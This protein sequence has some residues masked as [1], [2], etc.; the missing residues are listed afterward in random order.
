MNTISDITI[1]PSTSKNTE[2][3]RKY[4]TPIDKTIGNVEND[5]VVIARQ[6]KV[7]VKLEKTDQSDYIKKDA[8]LIKLAEQRREKKAHDRRGFASRYE[9]IKSYRN[10]AYYMECTIAQR[11]IGYNR[12]HKCKCHSL[13][14]NRISV[15]K[16]DG[17]LMY[18]FSCDRNFYNEKIRKPVLYK[19]KKV[20]C[21][22]C[23]TGTLLHVTRDCNCVAYICNHCKVQE[24]HPFGDPAL[25]QPY[26]ACGFTHKEEKQKVLDQIDSTVVEGFSYASAAKEGVDKEQI[27]DKPDAPKQLKREIVDMQSK[28]YKR[29]Q[30]FFVRQRAF[31]RLKGIIDDDELFENFNKRLEQLNLQDLR[32]L[33]KN[34]AVNLIVEHFKNHRK[35]EEKKEEKLQEN[36]T[37][38]EVAKKYGIKILEK[39][40]LHGGKIS[41]ATGNALA[42]TILTAGSNLVKT[43]VNTIVEQI[44]K[45]KEAVMKWIKDKLN[46]VT[47]Y[48]SEFTGT[49]YAFLE[50]F[51]KFL[52]FLLEVV[53]D[54]L[55]AS[56]GP[57]VAMLIYRCIIG[58]A[59]NFEIA[60]LIPIFADCQGIDPTIIVHLCWMMP[61][62]YTLYR[63]SL[64]PNAKQFGDYIMTSKTPELSAV[65]AAYD[66]LADE[67]IIEIHGG[68][69]GQ[70]FVDGF[71]RFS[72]IK[73]G[74]GDA[75]IKYIQTFNATIQACR[76]LST[77]VNAIGKLI[78]KFVKAWFRTT[79]PK[80]YVMEQLKVEGSPLQAMTLSALTIS[81]AK[82]TGQ[83]EDMNKLKDEYIK[84]KVAVYEDLSKKKMYG[85]EIARYI[86]TLDEQTV[87]PIK[88]NKE[89]REPF[90]VRL[91]G[92]P[93]T[94]KSTL[95]P[96]FISAM[97]NITLEEASRKTYF[98][99]SASEYMDGC[100]KG[101][102]YLIY[103]DFN[104]D[105]METDLKE[106]ILIASAG[107]L[108]P[109]FSNIDP[110]LQST[111]G[112]KGDAINIK[113]IVLCSN[114]LEINPTSLNSKEAI[115]RRK[116][117]TYRFTHRK[118]V[119][120]DP[121]TFKHLE[122]RQVSA[123]YTK[124]AA[125]D[126][127]QPDL[128]G[129]DLITAARQQVRDEYLKFQTLNAT[130]NTSLSTL[131]VTLHGEDDLFDVSMFEVSRKPKPL[132]L[133]RMYAHDMLTCLIHKSKVLLDTIS[134]PIIQYF[135][136]HI[137]SEAEAFA[138]A[139]S[140]ASVL[141]IV[142]I[143]IATIETLRFLH[144]GEDKN[145]VVK[146]KVQVHSESEPDHVSRNVA[147][148]QVGTRY[149]NCL[150]VSGNVCLIPRH[151][152]WD[153]K[154]YSGDKLLYVDQGTPCR[155]QQVGQA[156]IEF[157][158][159][160][161]SVAEINEKGDYVLYQMPPQVASK[162]TIVSSFWDGTE[163]LSGRKCI[164]YQMKGTTRQTHWGAVISDRLSISSE[165]GNSVYTHSCILT[166]LPSNLGDCGAPIMCNGMN[167][168]KIVGINSG[169]TQSR[170]NFVVLVTRQQIEKGLDKLKHFQRG[171]LHSGRAPTIEE[172]EMSPFANTQIELVAIS[173]HPIVP[174]FKT[175]IRPS[176]LFDKI[177]EHV[178]EPCIIN[179]RDPRLKGRNVYREN[180]LKY[181]KPAH[182]L[183]PSYRRAAKHVIET[184]QYHPSIR[185]KRKL[186]L[187]EAINGVPNHPY[188]TSMEMTTSAGLPWVQKGLVGPKR[189]LF[190]GE[191]PNLYPKPEL[192]K[193]IDAILLNIKEG[194]L[195]DIPYLATIK[196]ERKEIK[197]VAE[198]KSRMFTIPGV[199]YS[200]VLRMYF[201]PTLAHMYQCRSDTFMSIGMN[202]ASDE[203]DTMV[204]YLQEVGTSFEDMDY[205]K[206]DTSAEINCRLALFPLFSKYL[207]ED[208]QF[209]AETL[210]R[211]DAQA[212]IQWDKYILAIPGGTCSGSVLTAPIGSLIN[213]V[214][215]I[216]SWIEL[217]PTSFKDP[218]YFDK[219]V[220]NKNYGDDLAMVVADQAKYFFNATNISQFLAQYNIQMTPGDKG[221][222]FTEKTVYTFTYLKNNTRLFNGKYVPLQQH[223]EEPLNWIRQDSKSESPEKCCEDNCNSVLRALFFYGPER[224]N[225][226]RESILEWRNYK[227]ITFE[228]LLDE[229]TQTGTLADFE[230]T[231]TFS[232]SSP[233]FRN[234]EELSP[235]LHGGE[236]NKMNTQTQETQTQEQQEVVRDIPKLEA[237]LDPTRGCMGIA[238]NMP[239][240]AKTTHNDLA[241]SFGKKATKLIRRFYAEGK[242]EYDPAERYPCIH[243]IRLDQFFKNAPRP[244][245]FNCYCQLALDQ[246]IQRHR[247]ITQLRANASEI[248]SGT[249]DNPASIISKNV[250]VVLSEQ[251]QAEVVSRVENMTVSSN[252]R[253]EKFNPDEAYTLS[254]MLKRNNLIGTVPW[255]GAQTPNTAIFKADILQEVITNLIAATPFR[256]FHLARFK[257]IVFRFETIGYRFARGRLIA[258]VL[259]TQRSRNYIKNDIFNINTAVY[260]NGIS[261][262]P[263]NA[264]IGE[265]HVDY[266]FNKQYID[267]VNEDVLGQLFL[268]VQN[269]FVPGTGGAA[270]CE[271][272]IFM[273]IEEAEFK[274]PTAGT[275]TSFRSMAGQ[276]H[277]LD[278]LIDAGAEEV[279]KLAKEIIP[280]NLVGDLLAGVLDAP[281]IG[282]QP[283]VIVQKQIQYLNNSKNFQY[284]DVMTLDPSAQQL[285]DPEVFSTQRDEMKMSE[286]F[287]KAYFY[288][289]YPWTRV[290]SV[291]TLLLS[292]PVGPLFEAYQ[293]TTPIAA[294]H[295]SHMS[296]LGTLFQYWRGGIEY[297]FEIVSSQMH[298]GKID[299]CFHP[300]DSPASVDTFSY[301]ARLSQYMS[302]LH[303]RNGGN[304]FRIIVPYLGDAPVRSVYQGQ[305]VSDTFA[306]AEFRFQ[307]FFSGTVSLNVSALLSA[308]DSVQPD[309]DI[310]VYVRPAKDFKY[311]M[312]TLSNISFVPES[313][314]YIAGQLHSGEVG[315]NSGWDSLPPIVLSV[316]GS[317]A[318]D[319]DLSQFGEYFDS[320]RDV[321]KR[322]SL[323]LKTF[324]ESD[325][326][327]LTPMQRG[328]QHPITIP[329]SYSP[330]RWAGPSMCFLERI[331]PMYRNFRGALTH[332]LR[333]I[334][335]R[336]EEGGHTLS[337]VPFIA[338]V[339]ASSSGVL[340]DFVA[341]Q[342]LGVR[343]PFPTAIITDSQV[344]EFKVPFLHSRTSSL[345]EQNYD[346]PFDS[347]H[348]HSLARNALSI[349]LYITVPSSTNGSMVINVEHWLAL[350]D[351]ASFG[352]FIDTPRVS[353]P[354]AHAPDYYPP[355]AKKRP[356]KEIKKPKSSYGFEIL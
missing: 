296:Y 160:I 55:S 146:A 204:R 205:K 248:H 231:F 337:Q 90:I 92:A 139:S 42:S 88:P 295:L 224:F 348:Y 12:H 312:N 25:S 341:S 195:P 140:V 252:S 322:Y 6:K 82:T 44:R 180:M 270:E 161:E 214:Y 128:E 148:L 134:T 309:V 254:M 37:V 176:P 137:R 237:N 250:G 131:N 271:I 269:A 31:N 301:S 70:M 10:P 313:R 293:E 314:E 111:H 202:K 324:I 110:N 129:L 340:D 149:T 20:V 304:V 56:T 241:V 243:F 14:M 221:D 305:H 94:G 51:M 28:R 288:G 217:A 145:S 251:N 162:K 58:D 155:L 184:L 163:V 32:V 79:D 13:R 142:G 113:G 66:R 57:A 169:I 267:L 158:F 299:V 191:V 152:I 279:K 193:E 317:E 297:I 294:E 310:N 21:K 98:R 342:N 236:E 64:G 2:S 174:P 268:V 264:T 9:G 108:M 170:E 116:N 335:S 49:F 115:N 263:A 211:Y 136:R 199:A 225:K 33:P 213:Q 281:Q 323:E 109:S 36:V 307:D 8:K 130:V 190:D 144:S 143:G 81:A 4:F 273:S 320:L 71:E 255:T 119:A 206:F 226:V 329:L 286:I 331:A 242:I 235:S 171:D 52:Q 212:L 298:E 167:G 332:K 89:V 353:L 29:R 316:S 74:R 1:A 175:K 84:S 67:G 223:P 278:S 118:D 72:G 215:L 3:K 246:H 282:E 327:A 188:L 107:V 100:H 259:P 234:L 165:L 300:H 91:T 222:E 154:K 220:R 181:G 62:M 16:E 97:E 104:Q 24:Y 218:R 274:Q 355:A 308:P 272:K 93:K 47:S 194:I 153:S 5:G 43:A 157:E 196:D 11:L 83:D 306:P 280:D 189:K 345:V 247:T 349:Q 233:N 230:G 138:I 351:E 346:L 186:T 256:R 105:R 356:Q 354:V 321:C 26:C 283:N 303:L 34:Q 336:Y 123:D 122:I 150:F 85:V 101:I 325:I 200:I 239:L 172:I 350:A 289:S 132:N 257:R 117:L 22:Y 216:S 102:E 78:P 99:N 120:F 73:I 77:V 290:D 63:L 343:L 125:V 292:L 229:W 291:G 75:I 244:L 344:A 166:T 87:C 287:K 333:I 23:Y 210:F 192:Q 96:L 17:K 240:I 76:G 185:I 258:A 48:I 253:A 198:G 27:I 261:L 15:A 275:I 164:T 232:Q 151:L 178:T 334:V 249:I 227:L 262:D 284:V 159:N 177:V 277:G 86:K 45:A 124:S 38:E 219:F 35:P 201:L 50:L 265:I 127:N 103:D 238:V 135:E 54:L 19:N 41:T 39:V 207:T 208:E 59:S 141:T 95:A 156:D 30:L 121:V 114:V 302:S 53:Q 147:F 61:L 60:T 276:I 338:H 352:V 133:A 168:F 179:M 173:D 46:T 197:S 330:C 68:S 285:V 315:R 18:K 209:E 228:G 328:G 203:W 266:L 65:N 183:P 126:P 339:L 260:Q 40:E 326:T 106:L 318:G 7:Y 182:E 311:F 245:E 187:Q 80:A 319:V 69:V 347:Y 112:I